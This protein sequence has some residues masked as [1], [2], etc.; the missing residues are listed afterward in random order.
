MPLRHDWE[1]VAIEQANEKAKSPAT[2]GEEI[3]HINAWRLAKRFGLDDTGKHV[4][5]VGLSKFD[6]QYRRLGM[7]EATFSRNLA[8][9]MCRNGMVPRRFT[10][11]AFEAAVCEYVRAMPSAYIGG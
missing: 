5:N 11:S 10:E 2:P 7:T 3:P 4:M 8:D 1:T 9:Y 6:R